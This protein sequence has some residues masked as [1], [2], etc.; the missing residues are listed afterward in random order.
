MSLGKPVTVY[1]TSVEAHS[2]RILT[3]HL[4]LDERAL[5]QVANNG[6]MDYEKW[7]SILEPLLQQLNQV[8]YTE[9]PMPRPYPVV[10]RPA[11]S[12]PSQTQPPPLRDP[13]PVSQT[14]STPARNL[15]PVPPFPN[16]SATTT[17]HV[18]DSLPPSQD[19]PIDT[20]NELPPLLLQILKSVTHNLRSSFS[21]R[22]PHTIQRLAEL[23][24][25]PTTHYKTLPAWLRAIDRVVSVSS[26]ADI[27]PLSEAPALVNGVNGDGGGGILWNNSDT[28]NGY[29]SASLGSDESLGGALL[30]PIPWLRN[31]VTGSEDSN[32]ESGNLDSNTSASTEGLEDSLGMPV[33]R[34]NGDT[35]VPERPDGAVTQG[36]LIRL[37]QEA[38]VVPVTRNPPDSHVSG[39]LEENSLLEDADMVPHARGPDLVGSVDMGR[40]DGQ[41]VELRIGSPP[42]EDGKRETD[43]NDA[44]TVL[45]GNVSSA[46]PVGDPKASS[47]GA[48]STADS[49]DFEIVLED[50]VGN[51]DLEAMQLDDTG[52][53]AQETERSQPPDDQVVDVVLVDADGKTEDESPGRNKEP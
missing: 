19:P 42:G 44:Q 2:E 47:S 51:G 4:S 46:E 32:E 3:Q 6:E 37:E 45:P 22:P 5:E 36:E 7:P 48:A 41:D 33:T 8:V 49:E 1:L 16:S 10:N 43:A 52:T 12:S 26:P 34:M 25:Y 30:T 15:P 11:P 17:S 53:E 29:D 20:A 13:N 31:G 14:P 38:G 18:P 27:F 50:A 9:F 40:V 21:K 28:R 23:I 39:T 35:L 24:L